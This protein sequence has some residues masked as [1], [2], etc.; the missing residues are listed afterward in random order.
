VAVWLHVRRIIRM[1]KL[2]IFSLLT[3]A[4]ATVLAGC[5]P[6]GEEAPGANTT[7]GDAGPNN[8]TADGTE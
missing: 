1:K 7:S 3:I 4:F 5:A 2:F 8:K 6:A